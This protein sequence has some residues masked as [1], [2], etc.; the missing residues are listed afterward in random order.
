MVVEISD[1]MDNIFT[2]QSYLSY[3]IPCSRLIQ[4][5]FNG[6]MNF[7]ITRFNY[8][9]FEY[10]HN[11]RWEMLTSGVTSLGLNPVPP[12]VNI[13]FKF[14]TSHHSISL[15]WKKNQWVIL[16]SIQSVS[17]CF[18]TPN[19]QFLSYIMVRTNYIRWDDNDVRF[20]SNQHA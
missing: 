8:I 16:C 5:F 3:L 14:L 1:L 7:K 15:F 13:R 4:I 10:F 11:H 12:V 18:L 9:F 20:E 2:W 6:P 17:D 19:D